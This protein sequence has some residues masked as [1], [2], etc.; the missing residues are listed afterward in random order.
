[1]DE[2]T[3]E[4]TEASVPKLR[5]ESRASTTREKVARR[6]PWAPPSKLDAPPAPEGYKHRWIRRETMGF[7]DRMN[8]TSKLREGYELVRADEHPDFTSASLEDGR[9]AGVISVGALVLARI[10]EET[11]QERNAYYQNRARDQ[12]RAIDTELLKSNAH[13]S[14]RINAPERRSRTTF[15]SRPS[16]ET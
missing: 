12:Q 11:A 2:Q 10:P 16:A 4:V 5:R 1:M 15:G 6:K 14:M 3:Q 9:H 13:D 7:D 8:I